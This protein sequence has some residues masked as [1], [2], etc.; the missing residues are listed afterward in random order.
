MERVFFN[1]ITN[2]LEAM[3]EGGSIQIRAK[4]N[5]GSVLV[6]IEDT[7]HGI[8]GRFATNCLSRSPQQARRTA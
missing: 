5:N 8:R 4:E 6:E 7:G 1:L 3:P 2:A